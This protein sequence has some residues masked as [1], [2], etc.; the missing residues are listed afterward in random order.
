M[1][2][3]N[4]VLAVCNEYAM[5][6]KVLEKSVQIAKEKSVGLT[7]M[8]VV[9]KEFF[10]LPFF[11]KNDQFDADRLRQE[12][13]HKIKN[14]GIENAA[15]FVKESD[16]ADRVAL[17]AQREHDSL[18]I[19]HY[20]KEISADVIQK[21]TT[22]VLLLKEGIH[23]Y[24]KAVV[25]LD[26]VSNERC[27]EYLHTLF[28]GMEIVLYQDFQYVPMPVVDP[29]LEPMDVSMDVT[30][31]TELLEARREAFEEFCKAKGLKGVFEVGSN[32]IA[33]DSV[34]FAQKEK[35]DLLI[36]NALDNDTMLGSSIPEII[37]NAK[38]DILVCFDS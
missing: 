22:P 4:R 33:E 7:L 31:Y 12:L 9:E 13:S 17:E 32:G 20:S 28:E 35:A 10:E 2:K 1:K 3:L 19:M 36:I 8:F 29:T 27:L 23:Q 37:E 26:T 30:V 6:D 25:A 34:Q 15:V 21:T 16:T 24:A 38:S 18:I 11:S 14:L 5:C